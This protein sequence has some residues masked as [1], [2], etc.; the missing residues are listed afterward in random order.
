MTKL[1]GICRLQHGI[2][3]QAEDDQR[4][5]HDQDDA[6]ALGDGKGHGRAYFFGVLDGGAISG[7][8]RSGGGE[9]GRGAG[10]G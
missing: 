1:P 9:G 10:A 6:L 4:R 5:N 8:N 2:S 3:D 7:T